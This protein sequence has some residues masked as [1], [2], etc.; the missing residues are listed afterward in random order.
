MV[1][2]Y[3]NKLE[4]LY[5]EVLII[6]LRLVDEIRT[7]AHTMYF[8]FDA[9]AFSIFDIAFVKLAYI[10]KNSQLTKFHQ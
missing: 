9:S 8:E 6:V 4:K 1:V 5:F 10:V 3:N 2:A 7:V